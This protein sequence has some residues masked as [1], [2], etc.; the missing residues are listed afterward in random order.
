[1]ERS[2]YW[3][4]LQTTKTEPRERPNCGD[5]MTTHPRPRMPPAVGSPAFAP[6]QPTGDA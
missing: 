3:D 2:D 1:M 6:E 5:R 4:A